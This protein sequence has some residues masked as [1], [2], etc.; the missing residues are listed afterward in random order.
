MCIFLLKNDLL[1]NFTFLFEVYVRL[2]FSWDPKNGLV[3]ATKTANG[4]KKMIYFSFFSVAHLHVE[5]KL[6]CF[7]R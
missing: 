4:A 6:V 3:Y 1:H 2:G 5:I 7:Y